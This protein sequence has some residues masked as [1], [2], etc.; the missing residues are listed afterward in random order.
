[1]PDPLARDGIRWRA[2]SSWLMVILM[3]GFAASFLIEGLLMLSLFMPGITGFF[4][5]LCRMVHRDFLMKD[6]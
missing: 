3:A 1:M 5:P 4:S 6:A 2:N